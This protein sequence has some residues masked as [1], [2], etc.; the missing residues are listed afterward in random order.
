MLKAAG[1]VA[2]LAIG[3]WSMGLLDSIHEHHARHVAEVAEDHYKAATAQWQEAD[4]N[5][6]SLLQVAQTF[7]GQTAA[8]APNL[9]VVLR[10]NEHAFFT[11]TGAGLVETRR[12]QGHYV[13]G[14]SGFS[15]RI[16]KGVRYHVGGTRGTY[17]AGPDQPTVIDTGTAT[18]TDQRV[19][20][21]GAK[22]T[23]EWAFA[24]L[25]GY[26][27]FDSPSW[28]AIQVSNRQKTSGVLCD[29]ATA[30]NFQFRLTLALAHFNG[31]VP[32]LV[33]QLEAQL[34]QHQATRPAPAPPP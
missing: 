17:Q 13:G 33:T 12:G 9:P 20:F 1:D 19:V 22:Q 4:A 23:R 6:R 29:A 24:K 18:I 16:A 25:I 30:G 34:Q 8:D 15:F 7:N 5:L 11:L 26:Q 27:H 28:T 31:Q 2:T 14:Y 10:R 21:Q 3:V 32:A